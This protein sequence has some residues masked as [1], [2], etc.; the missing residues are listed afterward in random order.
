MN[1]SVQIRNALIS[2]YSKKGIDDIAQILRGLNINIYSTGGTLNHLTTLGIEVNSVE[3]LTGYPSILDGRVKT[4]HPA[5]FGGI[6]ARSDHQSELETLKLPRFD[7]VIVDLYPFEETIAHTSDHEEIIEKID[8]GGIS[9]IRAAAKNYSQCLVVASKDGYLPL[10]DL[11]QSTQGVSQ[12]DDRRSFAIEAFAVSSRYDSH[13]FNYLS[14]NK[15]PV[16]NRERC[17]SSELRYGENPHQ[18]ARFLGDL[19]NV[20]TQR[21]GKALS[22]NNLVDIESAL[23]LMRDIKSTWATCAI[24]K[25][26]NTCGLAIGENQLEAWN[27][28]LAGDPTSAFGGIIIFKT[29]IDI[30]TAKAVSKIFF[31]ILLAPSFTK[32]AL[33]FFLSKKKPRSIVSYTL[34]DRDLYQVKSMLGG[35]LMQKRDD[36]SHDFDDWKQA[37]LGSDISP[38]IKSD[39]ILANIAVK[40][41]K[42]NAIAIV[43]D[44]Q[45]IGMGCGQTSRVDALEQA[46]SKARKFGFDL[47]GSSL[48]SDA[49]FPFDDCITIAHNAGVSHIVQPG[50]SIRDEDTILYAKKHQLNVFLTGIRHFKH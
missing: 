27:K 36:F 5:V 16:V 39:L 50:G 45:L 1:D 43:K 40:H 7:L 12:L 30:G 3:S 9:L 49:F 26:T 34:D 38:E 17:Q 35:H 11:L 18:E 29:E 31:E 33:E 4:L 15:I 2:V 22:Y 48:A 37:S 32:E 20:L 24:F 13:I 46:I 23:A 19:S 44:N 25:H 14:S 42:S 8:I 10:K 28:A 47:A 6:L 21:A 41:L